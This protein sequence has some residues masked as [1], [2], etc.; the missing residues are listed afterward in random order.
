MTRSYENNALKVSHELAKLMQLSNPANTISLAIE[1]RFKKFLAELPLQFTVAFQNG[2]TVTFILDCVICTINYLPLYE[3][4]ADKNGKK[5]NSVSRTGAGGGA[6]DS[7]YGDFYSTMENLG[8]VLTRHC[9]TVY[10]GVSGN[11][12]AQSVCFFVYN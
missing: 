10:T 8:A 12:S 2:D 3:T 9:S 5:L 7:G 11:T 1:L 6:G 4:A